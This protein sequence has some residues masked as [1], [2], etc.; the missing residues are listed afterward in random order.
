M[1][2]A[3]SPLLPA[4]GNCSGGPCSASGNW[5]LPASTPRPL[6]LP[7]LAAG[8]EAYELVLDAEMLAGGAEYKLCIDF[9]AGFRDASG[10]SLVY[11]SGV[12]EVMADRLF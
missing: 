5:T 1:T 6:P 9:G 10:D 8:T 4:G 12:L 11:V 2:F 3:S 7:P